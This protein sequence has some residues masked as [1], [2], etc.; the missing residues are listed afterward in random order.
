MKSC[1]C[2]GAIKLQQLDMT[3]P[4][5]LDG[6]SSNVRLKEFQCGVMGAQDLNDVFR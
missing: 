1:A 3:R 2:V 4:I 5:H 6:M